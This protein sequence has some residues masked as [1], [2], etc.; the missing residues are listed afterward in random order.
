MNQ[1]SIKAPADATGVNM[2]ANIEAKFLNQHHTW[3][4]SEV[5]PPQ[6]PRLLAMV[7]PPI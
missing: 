4:V 7:T 1:G 3:T 5:G 2:A 6:A